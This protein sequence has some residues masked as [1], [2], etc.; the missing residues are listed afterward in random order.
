MEMI[1][2]VSILE[3][4]SMEGIKSPDLMKMS[5]LHTVL[6]HAL[7]MAAEGSNLSILGH[8]SKTG[9]MMDA[10]SIEQGNQ[11]MKNAKLL[12]SATM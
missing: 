11:M 6:N 7:E 12:L 3:K 4:M 2:A 5:H 10:Y 1:K 8:M 9:E